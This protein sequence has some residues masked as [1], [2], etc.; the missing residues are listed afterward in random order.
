MIVLVCG[1]RDFND[2][3]LLYS[4]LDKVLAKYSENL[5]ILHGSAKGAD[6]M[7]EDWAKEREVVYFGVPAKWK[8]YGKPAGMQRNRNMRD[9]FKPKACIAFRGNVG[10][11][12]MIGLM[13]ENGI[14]PW[15]VGWSE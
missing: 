11:R 4:T 15:I 8:K 13:R 12:G 5:V 2:K 7:A 6:L 14:E 9:V 1:G 3:D 10:T